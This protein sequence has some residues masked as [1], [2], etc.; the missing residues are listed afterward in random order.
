[1]AQQNN[2]WNAQS[3][4]NSAQYNQQ[5]QQNYNQQT[6]NQ[7]QYAQQG[8]GGKDHVQMP[9]KVFLVLLAIVGVLIVVGFILFPQEETSSQEISEGTQDTAQET[10]SETAEPISLKITFNEFVSRLIKPIPVSG[11]YYQDQEILIYTVA[12]GFE[13]EY[14]NGLYTPKLVYGL[15]VFN[16]EGNLIDALNL[17]TL[18]TSSKVFDYD[19]ESYYFTAKISTFGLVSGPYKLN[20]RVKDTISGEDAIYTKYFTI[21]EPK[22][23]RISGPFFGVTS[24]ESIF[25]N[26]YRTYPQ[27]YRVGMY[28]KL[29]GFKM[30]STLVGLDVDMN[31]YDSTGNLVEELSNPELYNLDV[32]ETSEKH[33]IAI[34]AFVDTTYWPVGKYSVELVAKDELSGFEDRNSAQFEV[35]A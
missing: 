13:T 8:R 24:N 18:K 16:P 30:D 17:P 15:Q 7:Q 33:S 32:A 19:P 9:W 35:V 4:Q 10:V 31:V 12:E 2:N 1:M 11:D 14:A 6:N 3:N 5:Y 25:S 29:R 26:E 22:Q 21:T 27:G 28:F 20:V 23:I 34:D